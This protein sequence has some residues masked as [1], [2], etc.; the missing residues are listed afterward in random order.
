MVSNIEACS[1]NAVMKVDRAHHEDNSCEIGSVGT[2]ADL[3]SA[4]VQ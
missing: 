3:V 4:L 2:F 1:S